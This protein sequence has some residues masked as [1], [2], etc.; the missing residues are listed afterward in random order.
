MIEFLTAC[1][2]T[3]F[4]LIFISRWGGATQFVQFLHE[5]KQR[6]G[7][8]L[9]ASLGS[10]V[11]F[12]LAMR[13]IWG[14]F[15]P[16]PL[17]TGVCVV[18]SYLLFALLMTG[19]LLWLRA[20]LDR[21]NMPSS[22][23]NASER[24]VFWIALAG[25]LL[26]LGLYACLFGYTATVDFS[27]TQC[28]QIATGT[29]SRIHPVI[30]TLLCQGLLFLWNDHAVIALFQ[31][32]C[33]SCACA[34]YVVF[35]RWSGLPR[36]WAA[37]STLILLGCMAPF[38]LCLNKDVPFLSGVILLTTGLSL[39]V[40]SSGQ[41]GYWATGIG[42]VLAATMRFDGLLVALASGA[43]LLFFS[44]KYK[45]TRRSIGVTCAAAGAISVFCV[46]IVPGIVNANNENTGAKYAK[47][48]FVLACLRAENP[49][50]RES[51]K[52]KIDAYILPWEVNK[53]QHS[54]L[55][56]RR[57]NGEVFM[58]D[59]LLL[60]RRDKPHTFCYGLTDENRS[61]YWKLSAEAAGE[62]PWQTFKIFI[63]NGQMIWNCRPLFPA[64][65]AFWLFLSGAAGC[66]LLMQGRPFGVLLP[67]IPLFTAAFAIFLAAITWELR[68][69]YA[70]LIAAPIFLGYA[71]AL[72]RRKNR[73]R[74]AIPS[75]VDPTISDSFQ[76][77][78]ANGFNST[79]RPS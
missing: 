77:S 38:V 9:T 37:G 52:Q 64:S 60:D 56:C 59:F 26:F 18:G 2:G 53:R 62:Y 61:V 21:K 34:V 39:I 30:H 67:A 57:H 4:F 15:M 33:F 66:F 65:C 3:L 45:R 32:L 14:V 7:V 12:P 44:F 6:P 13:D 10:L 72:T 63:L 50:M 27:V 42:L 47:Q 24:K 73:P 1:V 49:H 46:A 79:L 25:C 70:S 54:L 55:D 74:S 40:L 69:C 43:G 23:W 5:A 22:R 48:A 41:R 58:W 51:L 16:T 11:L 75:D 19:L 76:D 31:V 8:V 17:S 29:Y 20:F 68:Y 71:C 28:R 35:C 36:W 78:G